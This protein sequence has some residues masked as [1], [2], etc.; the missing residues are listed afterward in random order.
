MESR[1]RWRSKKQAERAGGNR[2][3]LAIMTVVKLNNEDFHI[4]NNESRIFIHSDPS[5]S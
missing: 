4:T 1:S 2:I 3:N 5:I